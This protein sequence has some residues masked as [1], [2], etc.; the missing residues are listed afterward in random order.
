MNRMKAFKETFADGL[1]KFILFV[2]SNLRN[3]ALFLEALL[4]FVVYSLTVLGHNFYVIL[5][6][7]FIYWFAIWFIKSYANKI[8][9]GITVPTPSRR[10]TEED[11]FNEITIDSSR[12]K[13]LII[14]M[15]D[16]EDWLYKKGLTKK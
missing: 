16:L 12:I 8:G 7:I 3:L 9:K 6:V 1:V 5:A 10:F 2:E 4:P 14:Y 15:A 13:E 11:E